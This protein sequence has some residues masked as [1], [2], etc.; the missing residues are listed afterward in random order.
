MSRFVAFSMVASTLALLTTTSAQGQEP[1]I[2]N[3]EMRFAIALVQDLRAYAEPRVFEAGAAAFQ[4]PILHPMRIT[5]VVCTDKDSNRVLP[6]RVPTEDGEH[7]EDRCPDPTRYALWYQLERSPGRLGW[8]RAEHVAVWN[9]RHAL[10]P[11][12]DASINLIA[13]YCDV[14]SAA[15]AAKGKNDPCMVFNRQVLQQQGERAPFPVLDI[16]EFGD[17]VEFQ[18]KQYFKV[19]VPTLYSNI[20]VIP[21]Q[22]KAKDTAMVAE[23]FILVDATNS[24]AEV[25]EGTKNAL[26]ELLKKLEDMSI[27]AR[28]AVVGY[29][30]TDGSNTQFPPMEGTTDASGKLTFVSAK[31]AA[32]FLDSLEAGGG[33]DPREAIWDALY[34][35]RDLPVKPG[36]SRMLLLVGDAPSTAETRGLTFG[37]VSVPAGLSSKDVLSVIGDTIGE[38]TAFMALFVQGSHMK[39][40]VDEIL[41]GMKFY[42]NDQGFTGNTSARAVESKVTGFLM[43]IS[44]TSQDDVVRVNEC[45]KKFMTGESGSFGFFCDTSGRTTLPPRL[46]DLVLQS[47]KDTDV[48]VLREIWVQARTAALDNVALATVAE[49]RNLGRTLGGLAQQIGEDGTACSRLGT[50]IWVESMRALVPVEESDALSAAQVS[51]QMPVVGKRLHDYWDLAVSRGESLLRWTPEEISKMGENDCLVK[52]RSRLHGSSQMIDRT[53]SFQRKNQYIWLPF[54]VIP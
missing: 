33:G 18:P 28:F 7:T 40:T 5:D 29:R 10:R 35:L 50:Q 4:M 22:Q 21:S 42:K 48:V 51:A 27:K 30:D 47:G 39:R 36:A 8:A 24:M 9:S 11:S 32:D 16:R 15:A 1:S 41:A 53:I 45:N 23:F 13:G 20:A 17:V 14:K 34:L 12:T 6:T 49:A 46:R 44:Q 25:I 3:S 52:I 19:L 31:Q 2:E 38:S 43:G 54:Q 26:L 37:G